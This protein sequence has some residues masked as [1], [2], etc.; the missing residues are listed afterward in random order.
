MARLVW[1]LQLQWA[2]RGGPQVNGKASET[3]AIAWM[4]GVA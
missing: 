3:Y 4:L 2:L 1:L